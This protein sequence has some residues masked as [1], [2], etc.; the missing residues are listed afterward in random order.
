MIIFAELQQRDILLSIT[1]LL[2]HVRSTS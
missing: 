2:T 1:S